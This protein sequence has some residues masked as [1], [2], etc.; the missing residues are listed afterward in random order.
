M[1]LRGHSPSKLEFVLWPRGAGKAKWVFVSRDK[2]SEVSNANGE[3]KN[4]I[5]DYNLW[6][7]Y[8]ARGDNATN[9]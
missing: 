3:Q 5:L 1:D 2:I 4:Y 9:D 7:R 8:Q 6:S